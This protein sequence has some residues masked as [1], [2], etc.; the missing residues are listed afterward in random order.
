MLWLKALFAFLFLFAA[1]FAASFLTGAWRRRRRTEPDVLR[2]ERALPSYDCGLCGHTDCRDYAAALIADAA[3]PARCGPGGSATE[4]RLRELLG[5]R[6]DDQRR[7]ERRAVIRCAG[8]DDAAR[9]SFEYDGHLD[10]ASAAL[11]YGGP[12]LCKDGCIGF[13][14]CV[15][16]CPLRAITVSRGCAWVD[17]ERCTGCGDCVAACPRGIIELIPVEQPWFVACSTHADPEK[18]LQT[19]SVACTACEECLRRSYQGEF[20]MADGLARVSAAGSPAF[21][22]IAAACPTRAIAR[23]DERKK[24]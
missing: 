3:D 4:A 20:V 6:E 8:T 7:Q 10:C 14:S 12:K 5:E 11:L 18:R 21:P 19:C 16:A 23:I 15:A 22:D 1:F 9:R 13:G 24:K 17:P 2:I